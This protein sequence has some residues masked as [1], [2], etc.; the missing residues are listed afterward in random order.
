MSAALTL[1]R[2]NKLATEIR[3]VGE[4]A[5]K[6]NSKSEVLNHYPYVA[7]GLKVLISQLVRELAG[8][9]AAEEIE[10]ACDDAFMLPSQKPASTIAGEAVPA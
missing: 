10:L 6:S 1:Q 8:P 9:I 5:R 4:R 3:Q 2:T 7:G